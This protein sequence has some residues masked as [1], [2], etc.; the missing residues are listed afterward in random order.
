MGAYHHDVTGYGI[1]VMA[2]DEDF[3]YGQ[4]ELTVPDGISIELIGD[5]V[6]GEDTGLFYMVTDADVSIALKS[7]TPISEWITQYNKF[8]VDAVPTELTEWLNK[9]LQEQKTER[10]CITGVFKVKNYG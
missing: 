1:I 5:L 7:A 10:H 4:E 9:T 6:L 2:N 3:D 8:T